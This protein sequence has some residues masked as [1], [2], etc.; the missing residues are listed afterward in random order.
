SNRVAERIITAWLI[1]ENGLHKLYQAAPPE[2][3]PS[4]IEMESWCPG[5]FAKINHF[6][7][8][9]SCPKGNSGRKPKVP[10]YKI[11]YAA[12]LHSRYQSLDQVLRKV[13]GL[14]AVLKMRRPEKRKWK[15]YLSK[16][17]AESKTKDAKVFRNQKQIRNTKNHSQIRPSYQY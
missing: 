14:D 5:I 16:N 6:R 3:E 12:K 13:L 4:I 10:D 2:L 1:F 7:V 9:Y 17:I 15:R 11:R 8:S